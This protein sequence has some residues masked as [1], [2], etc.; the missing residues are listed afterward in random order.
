[1]KLDLFIPVHF[2]Y[3]IN[4]INYFNFKLRFE[5]VMKFLNEIVFSFE[6]YIDPNKT[7]LANFYSCK[8]ALFISTPILFHW[9]NC[10]IYVYQCTFV[11]GWLMKVV[12]FFNEYH[13]NIKY[14]THKNI[15]NITHKNM[16]Y[17]H[18][19]IKYIHKNIKYIHKNIKNIKLQV[20]IQTTEQV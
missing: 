5:Y 19:N 12:K 20:F 6:F 16:K 8:A 11:K 1:M 17:I 18:K 13:K 10:I 2:I 7:L 14:I 3:W 4:F 9:F 15:K